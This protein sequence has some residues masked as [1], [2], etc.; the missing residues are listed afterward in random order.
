MMPNSSGVKT[1]YRQEFVNKEPRKGRMIFRLSLSKEE[2]SLLDH[3]RSSSYSVMGE[4]HRS[5]TARCIVGDFN[6]TDI[7]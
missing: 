7:K 3:L 1:F 2:T 6:K 4:F 5:L